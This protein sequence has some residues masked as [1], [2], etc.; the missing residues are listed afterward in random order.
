M[1]MD[2]F[3]A[4]SSRRSIRHFKSD[5]ISRENI[6]RILE[7]G[8]W[9][10]SWKN[11]QCPRFVAIDDKAVKQ[12]ISQTLMQNRAYDGALTAPLLIVVCAELGQ[13]GYSAGVPATD[14]GDWYMFDTA[15]AVQNIL[16]EAWSLGFGSVVIGYFNASAVASIIDLPEG[17]TVVNLIAIGRPDETPG[18]PSRKPFEQVC[19][20]N[21]FGNQYPS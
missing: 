8:R 3:K 13:S 6:L 10:P 4:I 14:K 16:L 9:A 18:I 19:F 11:S 17:F 15:L 12:H 1:T 5:P 7:A 2:I 20:L 21:R